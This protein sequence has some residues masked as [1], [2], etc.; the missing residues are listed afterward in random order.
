MIIPGGC[1]DGFWALANCNAAAK[2]G[3]CSL[4][5]ATDDR[6]V[7]VEDGIATV[8]RSRPLGQDDHE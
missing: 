7:T 5:T 4:T 8:S 3:L 2:L 1:L 6:I